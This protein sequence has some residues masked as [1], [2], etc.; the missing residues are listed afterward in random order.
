MIALVLVVLV[1][2]GVT[3]GVSGSFARSAR[4]SSGVTDN[5]FPTSTV[6]LKRQ[7]ISQ[8]TALPAT[9]GYAGSYGPVDQAAGTYTA[10]PAVGQVV[11]QGQVFY[12]VD[13][14]PVVLL[15]GS[16][17]AYRALSEGMA[18]TD[19]AELDADLVNLG[20]ATSA[21]FPAG[22]DTFGY[23]TAVGVEKLQAA[24]G[25]TQ[26][27]TLSV[28][29]AV[30]V[31]SAIRVTTVSG[32]VGGPAQPGQS[33]L[34]GTSTIRQVTIDLDVDLQSEVKAGD[35][36][37]ITLPDNS[38]TA[39]VV[40]SVGTVATA[41]SSSSGGGGN[42]TPTVTVEVA[43]A[44]PA[45]TGGLDQAPVT[46]SI[47]NTTVRDAL[48]APIDALIALSDGGYAIEIVNTDGMHH[49]IDVTVGLF[50][51]AANLVQITGP[52]LAVGE[53]VVVPAT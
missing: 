7:T 47:T 15:Y 4:G 10:L 29:Q 26:T 6:T 44:D 2:V 50:D 1:A 13:G 39:G 53:R 32:Q 11:S 49:L 43:P 35:R 12:R 21:E 34:Q 16:T 18:G 27:G 3:L 25:A 20:Y 19:V 37:T 31:P 28:G 38:T 24:L 8:Q 41:P 33:R 23:W 17:P 36:V 42:G 14:D 52:G 40:A 9:L 48:V 22:S 51:D 5:S 45:A 30:F 46:V